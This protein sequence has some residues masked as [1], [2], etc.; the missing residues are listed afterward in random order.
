MCGTIWLRIGTF[1]TVLSLA[2]SASDGIRRNGVSAADRISV[3]GDRH[4]HQK[5]DHA[6]D[7]QHRAYE[8]DQASRIHGPRFLAARDGG[9]RPGWVA[10]SVSPAGWESRRV[11]NRGWIRDRRR[12]RDCGSP[13]N[14]RRNGGRR[15]GR[16]CRRGGRRCRRCRGGRR[17]LLAAVIA[18]TAGDRDRTHAEVANATTTA[19]RTFQC[20][21]SALVLLVLTA[22]P[23]RSGI[24]RRRPRQ[25]E[26]APLIGRPGPVPAQ[27]TRTWTSQRTRKANMH[28]KH[29]T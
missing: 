9:D 5:S 8:Q 20:V 15:S 11:R 29:R 23:S 6:G 17:G 27:T 22:S 7:Q 12:V 16:R 24:A 1:A 13:R 4:R 2:A 18:I 19:G 14:D 21:I 26:A 3:A 25:T 28:A 10:G